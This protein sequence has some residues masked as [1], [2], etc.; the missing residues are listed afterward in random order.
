MMAG[1]N[2]EKLNIELYSILSK[3]EVTGWDWQPIIE[4]MKPYYRDGGQD[5]RAL[6]LRKVETL[7]LQPGVEF[8][9]DYE[10]LLEG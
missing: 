1:D 7:K 9:A 10:R 3:Q 6:I 4:A 5:D 8:P 2:M